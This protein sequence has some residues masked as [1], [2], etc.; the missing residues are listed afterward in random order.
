MERENKFVLEW[1][2]REA[3]R[4][5]QGEGASAFLA[6]EVAA[7]GGTQLLQLGHSLGDKKMPGSGVL[8]VLQLPS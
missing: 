7:G 8:T 5:R 2:E 4:T 6:G 3:R 1:E